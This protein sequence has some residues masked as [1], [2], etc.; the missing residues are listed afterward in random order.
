MMKQRRCVV[1]VLA[2][3]CALT[4]TAAITQA[5]ANGTLEATGVIYVE[6]IRVA[7]ELQGQVAHVLVKAGDVVRMGDPLVVLESKAVEASVE[8]AH[9]ELETAKAGLEVVRAGP[10]TA[11][12]AAKQ[13]QVAMAQAERSRALASY[14][15]AQ[16]ALD[17]PQ[18]LRQQL[19]EAEAQVAL[20]DAAV[21]AS[22]AELAW[23]RHQADEAD[24]NSTERHVLEQQAKAAEADLAA[25]Q[26]DL[27]TA[28]TALSHLRDILD[29]PLE[30]IAAVHESEG[31][32]RIS[33]ARVRVSQA[34]LRELI[35][36]ATAE[37]LAV[38]EAEVLLAGASL[39]LA[40]LR[41]QRLAI[42]S[43][44]DGTVT[45]LMASPGET[46]LPGATLVTVADLQ[47]VHVVVY[48]PQTALGRVFLGQRV[49]VTVDSYPLRRFE[50]LVT[51]IGSEAQYTPRNVASKEERVNTVYN[52]TITLPNPEGLLKGGMAAD[53]VFS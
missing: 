29:N 27:R 46:A 18:A 11:G 21:D 37:E 41:A 25:A 2:V 33:D 32:Y 31:A 50:G 10:R 52:V 12:V 30:Y 4:A 34:E 20:A 5:K 24:W 45:A 48:V 8:Q 23:S 14:R 6:E 38:V 47:D 1:I 40:K 36:G 17:D 51:H 53:A 28:E 7:S 9:S 49:E 26:A 43:P 35:R 13:A 19:L 39:N 22:E 15:A 42:G 44:V 3:A 16:R